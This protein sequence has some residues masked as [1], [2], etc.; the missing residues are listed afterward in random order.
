MLKVSAQAKPEKIMGFNLSGA[1][2]GYQGYKAADKQAR[3]EAFLQAQRDYVQTTYAEDVGNAPSR[4]KAQAYQDAKVDAGLGL[5]PQQTTNAQGA[6]TAQAADQA[7]AEK[8]RPGLEDATQMNDA[9]AS[10]NAQTGGLMADANLKMAPG[11]IK[12]AIAQGAMDTNTGRLHGMAA[13]GQALAAGDTDSAASMAHELADGT[14][15]FPGLK[16]KRIGKITAGVD[17]NG[18]KVANILDDQGQPL[19]SV[20]F[21]AFQNAIKQTRA[22]PDLKEVRA[23]NSLVS[24]GRNGDVSEVYKAPV[25][26]SKVSD[27]RTSLQKN[28]AYIQKVYG[29]TEKEALSQAQTGAREDRYTTVNRIMSKQDRYQRETDPAKRA[30]MR[31]PYEDEYDAVYKNGPQT[32]GAAPTQSTVPDIVLKLFDTPGL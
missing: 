8:R 29:L 7:F 12:T 5:L 24:V 13:I 32:A 11:K 26:E 6:L 19:S 17:A 27:G 15:I 25:D 16:G 10:T 2:A 20:P 9:T 4:A 31:K 21:A 14:D 3:D 28:A 18:V 22:K 1:L 30:A 23:G